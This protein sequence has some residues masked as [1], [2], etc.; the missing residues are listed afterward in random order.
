MID[1]RSRRNQHLAVFG[2][3]ASGVAAARALAASGARVAAWDDKDSQRRAARERGIALTD[4]YKSG[5]SELD[6]LVLAPGVPLT[7]DPH[8]IARRAQAVNKPIIGDIELLTEA[9]PRARFIGITGTNGKSTATALIGHILDEVGYD[10]RIGG[11]LGPPALA[12]DPPGKDSVF[13]LE[14]SSYQLDLTVKAAFDIAVW[15]NISPDHLDRHGGMD[16]YVAAKRRIFRDRADPRRTQT[17]IIGV[18]DARSAAV[19]DDME[20]REAWKVVSI[21]AT[22]RLER[23]VFVRN[24]ALYDAIDD[25]AWCVCDLTGIPTLPGEHNWQN[26]AAAYAA[27]RAIGIAPEAAAAAMT[28][29][30]GLP[31]RMERVATIGGVLYVNDSKAT[32]ADAAARAL[33]CYRPVYWIAGGQAKGDGLGAAL[34]FA[35]RIR[36]AFLIGD[37][38]AAFAAALKDIVPATRCGALADALSEAHRMAQREKLPGAVVLLSPACASFDQFR[39][40]EDRGNIFRKLV[41]ALEAEAKP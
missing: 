11:N 41:Q 30:P 26:A 6:A 22:R 14:L 18:D 7:H 15:L 17:A 40:F 33:A 23:G 36:H 31:H 8:P 32:N 24:G 19:R 4:L 37:A 2:L 27:A 20:A 10:T 28:S 5:F 1:I 9:C 21:S 38:E 39:N 3:G 29:Y 13:V 25:A 34:P 16:G 35:G 12:F